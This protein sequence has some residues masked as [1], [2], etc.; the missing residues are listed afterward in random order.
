MNK[1]FKKITTSRIIIFG[2]LGVILLGAF[3]LM[4][5]IS[6]RGEQ[7]ASFFDSLFTS[8]SAVCVTGLVV[9]DTATYWSLFGQAVI[10]VLIQ[11]G[12]LGVITIA[13]LIALVS[14]RKIGLIQRSLMQESLSAPQMA[15]IVKLT[16]FILKTTLIFEGAGM[17]ALAF[18]LC[19]DMGFLKGLWYSLFHAVSA[20]CNA[21]FDLMGTADAQYV[22]LTN[23]ADSPLI[24]ITVIMLIV[25]GGIGFLTWDDIK[26]KRLHFRKYRMQSKVILSVTFLLIAVPAVYNFFFEFSDFNIKERILTSLFQA[27]TPRTAGFNTVDY[28]SMSESGVAGTIV[29]MLIG[30]SPGSTAGGMKT[31]T[32]AVLAASAFTVFG[33]KDEPSFFHRSI[34]K[35]VVAQAS[36]ILFMYLTLFFTGGLIISRVEHLPVI[37]CLFETASAIGTV[38]LTLGLTPT[39]SAVSRIILIML[40][41]L[42]RVGGLT[43]VYATVSKVGVSGTKLPPE[44][45]T[46]G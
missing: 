45:I 7:S 29:L 46:V 22:S 28:N 19:P 26:T 25:I 6:V 33:R 3:L 24:N 30:G 12:G 43:F 41:F 1:V 31:T 16:T 9:H 35:Q 23:Y 36:A 18:R 13:A 17:I 38:G 21:G 10:L 4:L 27:V 2:F 34:G 20:F 40:M 15:G 44:K 32:L 5:P 42:G 11:I 8:T 14:G 37:D 39:L